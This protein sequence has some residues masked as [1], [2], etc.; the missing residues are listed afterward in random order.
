MKRLIL[1]VILLGFIWG[2]NSILYAQERELFSDTMAIGNIYGRAGDTVDVSLYCAN[3][4]VAIG[5]FLAVITYNDTLLTPLGAVCAERGCVLENFAVQQHGTRIFY[6]LGYTF[7]PADSFIARGYGNVGTLSFRIN[8]GAAPGR[9]AHVGFTTLGTDTTSWT[10]SMGAELLFPRT[11]DGSITIRDINSNFP[12][13]VGGVSNQTVS[14]GQTIQFNVTAS[15]PEGDPITLSAQNLPANATFPMVQ[16]DSV[17]SGTFTFHPDFNQGGDTFYVDFVAMD[18]H[19]N[20]TTQ[21]S[22]IIV[23]EQPNDF[24][25][26][27]TDQGG[28]PGA[29]NRAVNVSLFNS[30]PVYG[31]QF[32]YHYD[33]ALV[34][35]SQVTQTE[36]VGEMWFNYNEPRPGTII[37]LIFSPGLD[38]IASGSAPLA[39]FFVDVRA[40]AIF[41]PTPVVIDSAIEVIDSIG[42]SKN[43]LMEDGFFTVDRFGDGNLDGLI[44]VGDCITVVSYIIGRMDLGVRQFDAADINRDTRVNIGDLQNVIDIILQFETIRGE[45]PG[46]PQVSVELLKDSAPFNN[47][48]TVPMWAEL[49]AE[50]AGLQFDVTFNPDQVQ[51]MEIEQGDMISGM[52]MD[53]NIENN[54]IHGVVYDLGGSTFGPDNGALLNLNF[55]MVGNDFDKV[56]D[57]Q[58]TDFL[59]VN[60][61]AQFIPAEVK[62]QLPKRFSLNQNYPNPFN[63]STN[64]SFDMPQGGV[65][66]LLVF[67]L[68]G[69][70]VATLHNGYLPAGNHIINWNGNSSNGEQLASG[71]YFYS[72]RAGDYSQSLK[73]LLMK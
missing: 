35:V 62:G 48:L 63:A 20:T 30:I 69:R 71:I 13:V 72:L 36:R 49:D 11:R 73:M 44:N 40:D 57:I 24:V 27:A 55:G 39:Q 16:G 45:I 15:D 37:V 33:P 60:K 41:G 52:R 6:V 4:T 7:T 9:V 22:R 14:E 42:T 65:V 12:P 38:F 53:Y 10:D 61:G 5:G 28:V 54:R 31:V 23:F 8:P 26:V 18:D 66:E 67:D 58:L 17:V 1:I 2:G 68:L 43:M 29:T 70:Q 50:A 51:P 21:Q 59:I 3:P 25:F 64:I 56:N 46:S 19:N 47:V 32:Q 34:S